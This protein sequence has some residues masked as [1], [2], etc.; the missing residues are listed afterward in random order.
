MINWSVQKSPRTFAKGEL[1]EVHHS[2]WHFEHDDNGDRVRTFDSMVEGEQGF[3]VPAYVDE[4]NY[5]VTW[6]YVKDSPELLVEYQE[7][8]SHD[9]VS[10]EVFVINGDTTEHAAG[11]FVQDASKFAFDHGLSRPTLYDYSEG[12]RIRTLWNIVCEQGGF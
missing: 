4:S 1:I 6:F 5:G 2:K 7:L 8:A 10:M 9:L 11:I 12:Y 3:T